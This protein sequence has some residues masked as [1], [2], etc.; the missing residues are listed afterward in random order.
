MDGEPRWE[1]LMDEQNLGWDGDER[2][3]L[4]ECSQF[5]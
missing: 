1:G 2:I 4:G 5:H 3:V